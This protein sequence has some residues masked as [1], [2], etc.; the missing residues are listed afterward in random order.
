[1]IPLL[2]MHNSRCPHPQTIPSETSYFFDQLYNHGQ[3]GIALAFPPIDV[4]GGNFNTVLE[5]TYVG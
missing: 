2:P 1:M 4:G 5:V 3:L